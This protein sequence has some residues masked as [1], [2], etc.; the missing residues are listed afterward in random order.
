MGGWFVLRTFTQNKIDRLFRGHREPA[1]KH[2]NY[3]NTTVHDLYLG[4][5]R[6][7]SRC[8]R[9]SR[10]TLFCAKALS[11]NHPPT[12]PVLQQ[13]LLIIKSQLF[14]DYIMF[15]IRCIR[16]G[17]RCPR[18]SRSTLFSTKALST[19]HPPTLPVLQQSPNY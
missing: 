7:G 4:H 11:T 2:L 6:A 17:S 3:I 12:L 18:K 5:T 8:P 14:G 1:H 15:I 10:S 9:K 16:A 19:N 13:S